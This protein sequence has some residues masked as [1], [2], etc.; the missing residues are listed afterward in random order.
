MSDAQN[1]STSYSSTKKNI[2]SL[3]VVRRLSQAA[4]VGILGQWSFYGIFRCP[5]VVPYIS[6]QNC[7]VITC[8]GRLFTMFWGFWLLLPLS[9]F[10]FGRAFCGWVC[11]GG[12]VNQLIGKIAPFKLRTRNFVTRYSQTGLYIGVLLPP[13]TSIW[14]NP[15]QIFLSVQA[16][17]SNRWG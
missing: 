6:C 17:F 15:V 10:L 11:P 8:H 5:F 7:P 16:V 2:L 13:S 12:L 3:T 1:C 9:V 14:D 4:F